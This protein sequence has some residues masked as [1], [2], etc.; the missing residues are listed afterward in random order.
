MM[1]FDGWGWADKSAHLFLKH[2]IPGT[3]KFFFS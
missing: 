2:L 1:D 3:C